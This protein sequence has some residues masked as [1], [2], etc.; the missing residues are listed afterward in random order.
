MSEGTKMA[1]GGA[2]AALI[3]G[4][5]GFIAWRWEEAHPCISWETHPC[6]VCTRPTERVC[7][8]YVEKT[9]TYCSE[10]KP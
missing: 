8:E 9:C 1:I 2:V 3:I 4:M 6:T 10:R 7:L 5:S